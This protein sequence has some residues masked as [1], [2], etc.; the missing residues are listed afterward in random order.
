MAAAGLE[1]AVYAALVGTDAG[2]NVYPDMAAE[3]AGAPRIVYTRAASE[4][5]NSLNGH[6]LV[7]RVTIQ[8]E[9]WAETRLQAA[10]IARQ[11]RGALCAMSDYPGVCSG[12]YADFDTDAGLYRH[13]VDVSLWDK[14]F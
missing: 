13:I 12:E 4:P 1:S 8:L 6:S 9:I 14:S 5:I 2:T 3:G 7:D 10:Q 11:A